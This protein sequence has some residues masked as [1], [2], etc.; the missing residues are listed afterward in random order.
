VTPSGRNKPCMTCNACRDKR[1]KKVLQVAGEGAR[2]L[3]ESTRSEYPLVEGRLEAWA[4][5]GNRCEAC[6]KVVAKKRSGGPE[7]FIFNVEKGACLTHVPNQCSITPLPLASFDGSLYTHLL[8]LRLCFYE[9]CSD[10]IAF[11]RPSRKGDRAK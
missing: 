11:S 6:A 4:D 7:L 8:S 3:C 9:K 1:R 2:P 5:A 10:S